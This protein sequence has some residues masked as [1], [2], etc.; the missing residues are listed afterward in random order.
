MRERA[1][2]RAAVHVDAD[3]ALPG[4]RSASPCAV[5][6]ERRSA[7]AELVLRRARGVGGAG[8]GRERDEE[9]VALRVDLDAVVRSERVPQDSPVL[10]KRFRVRIRPERVE[11]A[12]RALDVREEEGDGAGREISRRMAAL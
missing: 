5:P 4:R 3:V 2:T 6:C 8:R 7:R 10:R 1:D 9:G 12:R 11:Q